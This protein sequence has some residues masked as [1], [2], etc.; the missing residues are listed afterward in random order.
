MSLTFVSTFKQV[1]SKF[2]NPS[3]TPIDTTPYLSYTTL[4]EHINI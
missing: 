2:D 1:Y 3:T 4:T